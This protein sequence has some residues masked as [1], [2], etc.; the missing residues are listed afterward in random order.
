[1]PI[2]ISSEHNEEALLAM[3]V[4]KSGISDKV[5][6]SDRQPAMQR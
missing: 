4:A 3:P 1:M 6:K 2:R 5:A